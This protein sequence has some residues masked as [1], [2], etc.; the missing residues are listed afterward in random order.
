V[1]L[2]LLD[3]L[4]FGFWLQRHSV[5]LA[6]RRPVPHAPGASASS[7]TGVHECWRWRGQP[8]AA[9]H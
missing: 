3:D 4:R 5:L 1:G 9:R 8:D 7:F 2:M 6:A